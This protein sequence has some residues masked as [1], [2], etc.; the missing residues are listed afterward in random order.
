MREDRRQ[1]AGIGSA[2][3]DILIREPDEFLADTPA[4]KGGM[5]YV[6]AGEI[7]RVTA[8]ASAPPVIVPGGAACNTI[9]G[10]AR[11][12]G[13]ALFVGKRGLDE[14]GASFAAHLEKS[15]VIPSLFSSA[16]PTG[17]VLSIITPDA[18]RSMLT[19]LG[20][21]AELDPETVTS[22]LFARAAVVLVEGYLIFNQ[23]LCKAALKAAKAAGAAIALD[24][25]AYTVVTEFR[26]TLKSLVAEYVDIL[27]AN[28]DEAAA[29]TGISREEDALAEMGKRADLAV[30]KMGGRGSLLLGKDSPPVRVAAMP[31][32]P[33]V[34]TT[35]AGDLWAAGFLH[36]LARG[37]SLEEAGKLGSLCGAE[38]CRRMGAGIPPEGWERIAAG[39]ADLI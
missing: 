13:E 22:S 30:V 5:I 21:S 14:F 2:L 4:E 38:A 7:E 8:A 16:S 6:S 10:V 29:F 19:C 17:R 3:M 35:G 24:L 11:L 33:V 9:I 27:I 18:Q 32:V 12:G 39:A 31:D 28:E 1:V 37:K 15:G 23:A 20:A 26:D 36:S 34:D 25:A